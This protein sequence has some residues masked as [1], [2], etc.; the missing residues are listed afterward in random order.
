MKKSEQIKQRIQKMKELEKLLKRQ[1]KLQQKREKQKLVTQL[2]KI[3]SE[4]EI[5]KLLSQSQK[6]EKEVKDGDSETL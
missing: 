2:V 5:E 4:E 6:Q 1:L 3:L